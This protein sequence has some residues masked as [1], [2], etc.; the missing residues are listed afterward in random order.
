MSDQEEGKAFQGPR[1]ES[2]RDVKTG[3]IR[4][5][6]ADFVVLTEQS[7]QVTIYY[8]R[9]TIRVRPRMKVVVEPPR[10]GAS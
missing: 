1:L 10:I 2:F 4:I 9:R 5:I 8:P 3:S 7:G 6:G